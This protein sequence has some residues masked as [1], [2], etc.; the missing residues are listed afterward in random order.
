MPCEDSVTVALPPKGRFLLEDVDLGDQGPVSALPSPWLVSPRVWLG[1]CTGIP[2]FSKS[3]VEPAKSSP[4]VRLVA[5]ST[6]MTERI[7]NTRSPDRSEPADMWPSC[8][9]EPALHDENGPGVWLALPR[10]LLLNADGWL[11]A[12]WPVMYGDIW[13]FPGGNACLSWG[14]SVKTPWVGV[15]SSSC[16]CCSADS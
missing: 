16:C 13:I 6:L 12:L 8:L 14:C 15:I 11:G 9:S 10:W 2:R 7:G 1:R 4:D 5:G 3:D